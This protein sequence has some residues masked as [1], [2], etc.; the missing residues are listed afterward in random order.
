[1]KTLRDLPKTVLFGG[2]VVFTLL[3]LMLLNVARTS[4][5][6]ASSSSQLADATENP[7]QKGKDYTPSDTDLAIEATGI[8]EMSTIVAAEKL[9]TPRPSP[10]PAF[11]PVK[12]D[13]DIPQVVLHDPYFQKDAND[14]D[15]GPCVKAAT[16]GKAF[17]VE[18]IDNASQNYYL[19]PFYMDYEVCGVA[20]VE[21][22]N[23]KGVMESWSKILFVTK[24]FPF[25]NVD[26]AITA[27]QKLNYQIDGDPVLAFQNLRGFTVS[28]ITPFWKINTT[29]GETFYV[30]RQ[31]DGF[32]VR[33]AK[34]VYPI[35]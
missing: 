8:A 34:D 18:Y 31:K 19:I 21:V 30:I 32:E 3:S 5:A 16:P 17:F 12:S 20:V 6:Q 26:D 35:R 23:G 13:A 7:Y 33:N 2:L 15:F 24:E 27:V 11:Y 10:T 28:E 25:V 1:M 9:I 14:P 29:T 4:L 22:H